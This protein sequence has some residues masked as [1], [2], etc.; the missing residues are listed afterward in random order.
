MYGKVDVFECDQ[1][2]WSYG[3]KEVVHIVGERKLSPY[4]NL[5]FNLDVFI[6]I[7]KIETQESLYIYLYVNFSSSV[8]LAL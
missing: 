7:N 6:D 3:D 4:S 5:D 1:L 2:E 8:F